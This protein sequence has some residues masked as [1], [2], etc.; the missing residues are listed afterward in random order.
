MSRGK[1]IPIEI[2]SKFNRLTIVSEAE[3]GYKSLRMVNCICECGVERLLSFTDVYRGRTKSCGCY[4]KDSRFK[5][6]GY[7]GTRTFRIW[8]AMQ[9]RC[10]DPS[11]GGYYMYGAVGVTVCDRWDKSKGGCFENFLEDMGE[12]PENYSINRTGSVNLY[13]KETCEWVSWTTQLRDQKVSY[14]SKT[15]IR[16]VRPTPN[17]IKYA[18]SMRINKINRYFGTYEDFFEACCVRKSLELQYWT[19]IN[20]PHLTDEV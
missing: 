20:K 8:L 19:D 5:T 17:G 13:S 4:V 1:K 6:H 9:D 14:K 10:N 16:G 2:G 11:A 12:C 15:G 3:R 18:V 7:T